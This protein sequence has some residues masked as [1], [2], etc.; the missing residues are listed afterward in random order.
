MEKIAII[1]IATGRYISL[2]DNLQKS[3]FEKFLPNYE[4]TIFLFTD[5]EY[6]HGDNIKINKILHLTKI[7]AFIF[8]LDDFKSQNT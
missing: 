2:F 8:S 3:I 5:S 6:Y 4:K 7:V 1:S